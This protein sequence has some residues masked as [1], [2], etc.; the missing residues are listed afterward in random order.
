MSLNAGHATAHFNRGIVLHELR[1]FAEALADFGMA[2]S[3]RPEY[4]IAYRSRGVTLYELK[5]Y[6]EALG[7]STGRSDSI[8]AMRLRGTTGGACCSDST[9]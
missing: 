3:L 6:D 1:R 8:P 9:S 7:I 4:A 5:R 2:I